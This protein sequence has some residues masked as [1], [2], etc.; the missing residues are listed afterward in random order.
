MNQAILR[1]QSWCR[2]K[3]V[4]EVKTATIYLSLTDVDICLVFFKELS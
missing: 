4:E 2:Q 1:K 3:W